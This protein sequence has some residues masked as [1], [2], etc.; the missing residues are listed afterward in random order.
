MSSSKT[1]NYGLHLWQPEDDFL[2][3]EF[4]ENNE[5]VDTA[6]GKLASKIPYVPLMDTIVSSSA[7][8]INL[9]VSDIDFT[10][11]RKVVLLYE[12][13]N[14][15]SQYLKVQLNNISDAVYFAHHNYGG[16]RLGGAGENC[17]ID[18]HRGE[19]PGR[20][21]IQVDFYNFFGQG[22]EAE[23][24]YLQVSNSSPVYYTCGK[25]GGMTTAI[26]PSQITTIN[27]LAYDTGSTLPQG[28]RIRI[29]GVK[30]W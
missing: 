19:F 11:W 26:L 18:S 16:G 6:L 17:L 14:I 5:A 22:I 25:S 2:R 12:D 23:I 29:W 13:E 8:Q 1:T 7:Y 15:T 24:R 10:A 21:R 27:L 9:D 20:M 4:N 30:T 3:S 28:A